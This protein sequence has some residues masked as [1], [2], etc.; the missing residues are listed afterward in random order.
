MPTPSGFPRIRTTW[1]WLMPS[2]IFLIFDPNAPVRNT[3]E[4]ES[5][6]MTLIRMLAPLVE[7]IG[8]LA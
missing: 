1:A 4:M 7:A 2:S 3:R 5:N 8:N 6:A